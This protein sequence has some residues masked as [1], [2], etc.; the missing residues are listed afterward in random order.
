LQAQPQR[1]GGQAVA[2]DFPRS[3]VTAFKLRHAPLM[4]IEAK[5]VAMPGQ[6]DR[7]WQA[8]I[9]QSQDDDIHASLITAPMF[10][11]PD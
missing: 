4:D 7:Q 10:D 6:C 5:D 11:S 8:D 2:I 3:V 9:A 1:A